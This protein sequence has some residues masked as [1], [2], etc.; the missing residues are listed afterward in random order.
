MKKLST[1]LLILIV[2]TSACNSTSKKE[3]P[4]TNNQSSKRTADIDGGQADNYV[5]DRKDAKKMFKKF[6]TTL[7]QASNNS[8]SV[9][10]EKEALMALYTALK[11]SNLK[12][13]GA[14]IYFSMYD[15]T[16]QNNKDRLTVFIVPTVDGGMYHGTQ[17]HRDTF[18]VKKDKAVTNINHGELCPNNCDTTMVFN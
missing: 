2:L 17:Y 5:I 3:D 10:F 1:Y 18:A 14:R 7:T 15:K 9:W 4:E 8:K 6:D 16:V 11:D 12:A 13:D